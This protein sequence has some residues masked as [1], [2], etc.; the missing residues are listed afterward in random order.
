MYR[1]FFYSL[2]FDNEGGWIFY[3]FKTTPKWQ[4][5]HRIVISYRMRRASI[6]CVFIRVQN[7][8][9]PRRV[10]EAPNPPGH[11]YTIGTSF[12][13]HPISV[14]TGKS[15]SSVGT[16]TVHTTLAFHHACQNPV[17]TAELCVKY[18]ITLAVFISNIIFD[19]TIQVWSDRLPGGIS[20]CRPTLLIQHVARTELRLVVISLHT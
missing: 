13:V 20:A 3:I 10:T 18:V 14:L 5:L 1:V 2:R 15:E 16:R 11:R 17:V 9:Q 7:M 12:P 19:S 6:V 4:P 8:A